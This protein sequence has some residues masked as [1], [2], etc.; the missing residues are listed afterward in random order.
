MH[1]NSELSSQG[2]I[3]GPRNT[4]WSGKYHT[5]DISLAAKMGT[6]FHFSV[7]ESVYEF[8]QAKKIICVESFWRVTL[9]QSLIDYYESLHQNRYTLKT[10]NLRK[11]A[12]AL[13][14]QADSL[15]SEP[16]GKP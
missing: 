1:C 13:V 8:S 4:L 12:R 10:V 3:P 7:F 5:D 2:S 16:P 14:L 9:Q 15:S 6:N 11:I